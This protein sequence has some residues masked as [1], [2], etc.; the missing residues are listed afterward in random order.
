VSILD[1]FA[2]GLARIRSEI[3]IGHVALRR[4]ARGHDIG[5]KLADLAGEW[6]RAKNLRRLTA[7]TIAHRRR[8]L[9]S[10][11]TSDSHW[12]SSADNSR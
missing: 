11:G 1:A 3:W 7:T 6:A 2:G 12:K 4:A 8:G 10:P 5:R 9:R